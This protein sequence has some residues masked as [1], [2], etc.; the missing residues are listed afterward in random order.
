MAIDIF[1]R[2]EI[3]KVEDEHV[4]PRFLKGNLHSDSIIDAETNH[5]FGSTLDKAF[6]A[7]LLF[8]VNQLGL[9]SRRGKTA[10]FEIVPEDGDVKIMSGGK[11][12]L[13]RPAIREEDV[14]GK[15]KITISAR[16]VEELKNLTKAVEKKFSVKIDLEKEKSTFWRKFVKEPIMHKLDF[17]G[18][19]QLREV[20][21]ICLEF[22][23]LELGSPAVLS[24]SFDDVRNWVYHGAKT[25]EVISAESYQ[26]EQ[27]HASLDH[28]EV[29]WSGLPEA[30]AAR[31]QHRLFLF[32]GTRYGGCWACFE[33]FHFVRFSVVLSLDKTLPDVAVGYL[34]DPLT[35]NDLR[36]S[37]ITHSATTS[38]V[39]G[40]ELDTEALNSATRQ[41][42]DSLIEFQW[43]RYVEQFVE[44]EV[45]A[46]LPEE[47]E[48]IETEH[49]EK[50]ASAVT[51]RLFNA[52][53]KLDS[54]EAVTIDEL[55]KK[56]RR[57]R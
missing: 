7:D 40:H 53:N 1:T 2:Q 8:F 21:K 15:K 13:K 31:F 37:E 52:L 5:L 46:A 33:I 34:I 44:E 16:S 3:T 18:P 32:S 50:I 23:A 10:G 20:A 6:Q 42:R 49:F 45:A 9:T 43:H 14:E 30:P 28:R 57:G 56:L 25:F 39:L 41:F 19:V 36:V 54:E 55:Q 26:E 47:R 48:I 11:P 27:N 38:V 22:A 4:I 35:E 51:T 29:I 17:G 24:A 12:M